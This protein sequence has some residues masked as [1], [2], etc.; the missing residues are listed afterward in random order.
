MEFEFGFWASLCADGAATL[1]AS[2]AAL[3]AGTNAIYAHL[4]LFGLLMHAGSPDKKSKT[5]AMYCPRGS[6][7]TA[8]ATLRA[9]FLDCGGTVSFTASTSV[10]FFTATF[11][12]NQ[13][14]RPSLWRASRSR[15]ELSRYSR[16]A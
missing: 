4:R 3:L 10:R 9:L 7:R 15:L 6:V 2:R 16:A 1:M 12:T 5:E 8:S 14:S 11:C 13:Q